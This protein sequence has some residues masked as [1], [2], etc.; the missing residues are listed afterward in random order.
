M[1]IL[2]DLV[3]VPILPVSS[4]V[5]PPSKAPFLSRDGS[6]SHLK[7]RSP[8]C[9]S[10]QRRLSQKTDEDANMA[11]KK[12]KK[13]PSAA[14]TFAVS[15]LTLA[16]V[17]AEIGLLPA[18]INKD[19]TF[20]AYTNDLLVQDLGATVLCAV[21]AYALVWMITTAAN[22]TRNTSGD[23]WL[24]P[25]DSRKLV[26]TLSAPAFLLFWPMF[27]SAAIGARI[28]CAIVPLLNG[29]RLVVAAQD[30]TNDESSRRLVTAVSRSGDRGEAVGG[31]LIY[32]GVL[33]AVI[34]LFWRDSPHAVVAVSAMAAGDGVAD[35]LG[36]RY[37]RSN[38]WPVFLTGVENRK[39]L[40][41]SAAFLVASVGTAW[42][43]LAWFQ[44]SGCLSMSYEG[45]ELFGRLVVICGTSAFLE[46]IPVANDNYTVPLSAALLSMLLLS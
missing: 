36:R 24:A 20:F 44:A 2:G 7:T 11:D 5:S 15:T 38:P 37:G 6:L 9:L 12:N 25:S 34:L 1:I 30:S 17:A 19:G 40:V 8:G 26:H 16:T 13:S 18:S 28:F 14:A 21:L 41:G 23:T 4:L 10:Q 42:G 35:L 27:S 31:P 29:F 33:V 32:V 39:S 22:T 45:W 46:L 43:L 3:A